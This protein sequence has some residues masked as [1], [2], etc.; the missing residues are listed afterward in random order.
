L[1]DILAE[2][3]QAGPKTL[4]VSQA[5]RRAIETLGPELGILQELETHDIERAG[6]PLLGEAVRRMRARRIDL[7][8]GYDGEYGRVRIFTAQERAQVQGQRL[9]FSQ[10]GDAPAAIGANEV[11]PSEIGKPALSERAPIESS[12]KDQPSGMD[13]LNEDQR[14]ILEYDGDRLMIV[15]GP[16]TGKTHTLTCRIARQISERR[17]PAG[18]VLAVTFTNRAAEEMRSRLRGLLG[19]NQTLPFIAT[20][21]GLCLHLLLEGDPQTPVGIIDEDEQ[22]DLLKQAAAIAVQAGVP[23]PLNAAELHAQIMRA[24]QNLLLPEDLAESASHAAEQQCV[25]AVYRAYRQLMESQGLL[26]FEDLIF[27]AAKRLEAIPEFGLSCRQRFQHVFVDEYQDLNYGQYR[28]IRSLVP[29]GPG[30]NTLCVIGDPDQ[31]IYGFRGSDSIY[32]RKFLEDYPDATVLNLTRNYRS[33]RAILSASFQVINRDGIERSRTYSNID[34]VKTV[35]ILEVANEHAEA[36]S[37]A[38]V[39]DDLVGGSGFHSVDTGRVKEAYPSLARGYA[40]FAVLA[41]TGDQLRL[42][43]D[44]LDSF[45]IPFQTLSRRRIFKEKGVTEMLSLL[46]VLSGCGSYADFENAAAVVAPNVGKR[47]LAIFRDWCFKSRLTLRAGLLNAARF[48]IAGLN[49]NQQFK[50]AEVADRLSAMD[51]E[52]GAANGEERLLKLMD[53]PAIAAFFEE[54][55]TK[56]ALNR[57]AAWVSDSG[58]TDRDFF[59]RYTLYTDTDLYH[60]RAEKTAVMTM[61][62][63][64]GLEF[65]VVFIAGCEEGLIPYRRPSDRGGTDVDEE[66]RL[67]YV[68]M[69]RAKERLYLT[70]ARRRRMFGEAADREMSP[71]VK[72]IEERL[73]KD[74]SP[75]GKLRR[76]KPDQLQLF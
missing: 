71:F 44:A 41:R 64:K 36:E 24:K 4:K 70:R 68:A 32:F 50:L 46:K 1:T 52:T 57:F 65:P 26:D 69:T 54:E 11:A 39:I 73:L 21:H 2:I 23:V 16:G 25:A 53:H 48:P 74:E 13:Q 67:F 76:K 43:G 8:P 10:P 72:H 55:K 49:R 62:A 47:V 60:P 14:R 33:T 18:R 38:R 40:D 29:T 12:P 7:S 56:A 63:A 9:L 59:N 22:V 28:V 19:E 27:K 17:V 61:H 6:I 75:R 30:E 37:I 58:A 35:S 3:L 15:A 34:G 51:R 45:G 5:Y 66:R 20:F 42:I 31:S